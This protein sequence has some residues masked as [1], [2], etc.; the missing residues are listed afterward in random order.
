MSMSTWRRRLRGSKWCLRR[1]WVMFGRPAIGCGVAIAMRGCTAT[2]CASGEAIIGS[3]TV[4]KSAAAAG[5][6]KK[7]AGVAEAAGHPA[8]EPKRGTRR[9]ALFICDSDE[10][11]LRH[12]LASRIAECMAAGFG[13]N[14]GDSCFG[15]G[16][17]PRTA[18][19]TK[20]PITYA[21]V[22]CQPLRTQAMASFASGYRLDRATPADDPNQ[23]SE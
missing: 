16:Y 3:R 5:I 23:I 13:V 20:N 11:S 8:S 4:G 19:I 14:E 17:Q 12:Q 22:T 1:A 18:T 10:R 2:G 15:C 7:V 21:T 6:S 9:P